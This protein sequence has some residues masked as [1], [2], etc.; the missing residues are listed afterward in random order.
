MRVKTMILKLVYLGLLITV[1]VGELSVKEQWKAYKKK[2]NKVYSPS[3]DAY[4]FEVFASNLDFI[5]E[6]NQM[7]EQGKSNWFGKITKH[8]DWTSREKQD[9][10][11]KQK[12]KRYIID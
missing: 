7:H 11:E 4:R 2:Y 1:V 5:N 10:E 6:V 8:T 9:I 3:E 12:L